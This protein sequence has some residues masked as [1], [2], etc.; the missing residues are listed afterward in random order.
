MIAILQ[1]AILQLVEGI[2]EVLKRPPRLPDLCLCALS[3]LWVRGGLEETLRGLE[4]EH[5]CL[6]A[7]VDLLYLL[8][9]LLILQGDHEQLNGGERTLGMRTMFGGYGLSC[10]C[11]QRAASTMM[12]AAMRKGAQG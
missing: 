11:A 8:V 12:M 3:D 1:F 2:L 7:P 6:N 4:D 5:L 9:L 10:C